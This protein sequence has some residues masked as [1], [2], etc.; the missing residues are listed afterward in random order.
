MEYCLISYAQGQFYP[1][2][3]VCVWVRIKLSN[4]VCINK[5]IELVVTV[6]FE[7]SNGILAIPVFSFGIVG[8]MQLGARS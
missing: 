3:A 2:P 8:M 7:H 6:Y 4:Y 5:Y 1:L